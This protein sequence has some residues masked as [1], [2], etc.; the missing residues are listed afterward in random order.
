MRLYINKIGYRS[1]IHYIITRE[2]E[3]KIKKK[4]NPSTL[5]KYIYSY[6][7]YIDRRKHFIIYNQK[8]KF[9]YMSIL[10]MRSLK[11]QDW[12]I[13]KDI[14]IDLIVLLYKHLLKYIG[15]VV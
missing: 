2:S 1:K 13:K 11:V 10:Q 9:K 4:I 14:M 7:V 3:K 6:I 5:K 12:N 15:E 8:K